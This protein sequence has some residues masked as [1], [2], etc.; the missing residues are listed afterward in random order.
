M[1][2]KRED[3]QTGIELDDIDR[4]LITILQEDGRVSDVTVAGKLDISNDTAKRRR[5]RLEKMGAIKI[6]AH[7]N[8]RKF[9]YVHFLHLYITTK[10][11]VSTRN[12]AE[13]VSLEK[14]AYYVALS[15]GPE[16]RVLVHYRGKSDEELYDFVER[17]RKDPQVA[18]VESHVVYEVV[19]VSYH[20]LDLRGE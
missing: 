15:M 13:Q 6:K 17:M 7:V 10:P 19:K 12:F 11:K 9:G 1:G 2:K 20:S 18:L 5:Q 3:K 14:N 4:D 16:Q 8:P